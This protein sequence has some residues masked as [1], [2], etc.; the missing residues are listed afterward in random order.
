MT[1]N[2]QVHPY[3]SNPYNR[4]NDGDMDDSMRDD[5][6]TGS[7]SSSSLHLLFEDG[8]PKDFQTNSV[9][10]A[11]IHIDDSDSDNE[12]EEST[13]SPS[14]TKCC[15]AG[16]SASQSFSR[17]AGSQQQT[18]TPFPYRDKAHNRSVESSAAP[19]S[20]SVCSTS[21][22]AFE[23]MNVP[24][25][26]SIECD[27]NQ[28]PR[29]SYETGHLDSTGGGKT[30]ESAR[31]NRRTR[32]WS[33]DGTVGSDYTWSAASHPS[34]DAANIPT[35]STFN[36]NRTRKWKHKSGGPAS[37]RNRPTRRDDSS[38]YSKNLHVKKKHKQQYDRDVDR[39]LSLY[40]HM[41]KL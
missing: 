34:V 19:F 18:L 25:Q 10:Q 26:H 5:E 39:E 13:D 14:S 31:S 29:R 32:S 41:W 17:M 6:I 30:Q 21:L 2:G 9:V 27:G 16:R 15:A 38:P 28:R 37:R 40:M 8:L 3:S 20:T 36:T 1:Q 35:P 12:S 23:G 24:R 7:S 4:G 11:A 22:C 33:F